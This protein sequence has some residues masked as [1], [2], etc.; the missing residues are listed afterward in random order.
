MVSAQPLRD[1]AG[2]AAV[3]PGGFLNYLFVVPAPW[4]EGIGGRLLDAA[5]AE[6][7]RRHHSRVHLWTHEENERSDRLYRSRGFAPTGR[8]AD[9]E[10]EWGRRL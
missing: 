6:A 3:P 10:G 1:D 5:L 9:G 2:A 7:D 4:A 8:T